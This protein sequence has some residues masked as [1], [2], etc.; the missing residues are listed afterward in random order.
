MA[1]VP[2]ISEAFLLPA[3]KQILPQF[4]FEVRGFAANTS[5]AAWRIC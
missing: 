3:L 4:P 2:Q 5:I 1:C